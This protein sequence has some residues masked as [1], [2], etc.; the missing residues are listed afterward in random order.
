MLIFLDLD[1]GRRAIIAQVVASHNEGASKKMTSSK[2]RCA[3]SEQ[4]AS[5]MSQATKVVAG[6]AAGVGKVIEVQISRSRLCLHQRP[7]APPH[8]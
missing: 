4:K 5:T 6:V 2:S 7:E 8:G 1:M 3:N